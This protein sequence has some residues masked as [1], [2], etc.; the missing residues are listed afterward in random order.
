MHSAAY[1][2][3]FIIG[4]DPR[5]PGG[6]RG[7][8]GS[9]VKR[10]VVSQARRTETLCYLLSR[11]RAGDGGFLLV[12][13]TPLGGRWLLVGRPAPSCASAWRRARPNPPMC[14]VVL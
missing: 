11:A 10:D 4:C 2:L 9:V 5:D 13:D 7:G 12:V 8:A 1:S 14:T 3:R 6:R